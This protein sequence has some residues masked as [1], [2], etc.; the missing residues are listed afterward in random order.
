LRIVCKEVLGL[1]LVMVY[2]YY[3]FASSGRRFR[4]VEREY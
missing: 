4:V 2:L 1:E 3:E